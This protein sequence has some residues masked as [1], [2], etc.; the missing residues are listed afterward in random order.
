MQIFNI[1]LIYIK[2]LEQ[3]FDSNKLIFHAFV[4]HPNLASVIPF[5]SYYRPN[6]LLDMVAGW[7]VS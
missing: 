4:F 2:V 1:H 3:I 5:W 6:S 7:P